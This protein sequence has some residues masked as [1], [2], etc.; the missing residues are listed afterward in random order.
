MNLSL[1]SVTTNVF[2]TE[3][4]TGSIDITISGGVSSY[5]FLWNNGST[6]EDLSNASAGNILSSG[7][8]KLLYIIR[9]ILLQNH[10]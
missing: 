7:I 3:I 9:Y 5:S 4:L 2:V 1:N 8:D 10:L 6:T